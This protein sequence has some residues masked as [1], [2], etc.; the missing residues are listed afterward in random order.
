MNISPF[1]T[2]SNTSTSENAEIFDIFLFFENRLL[3]TAQK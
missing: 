1:N 3:L 2:L